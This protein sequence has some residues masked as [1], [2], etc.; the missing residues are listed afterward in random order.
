MGLAVRKARLPQVLRIGA[1]NHDLLPREVCAQHQLVE[2]VD[3]GAAVP[4]RGDRVGEPHRGRVPFRALGLI[5]DVA[6]HRDLE[7]VDPHREPVGTRHGERPFFE[8][9]HAHGLQHRQQLA[10]RGRSPAEVPDQLRRAI[11]AVLGEHQLDRVVLQL[12]DDRDVVDCVTGGDCL[13]VDLWERRRVVLGL[14]LVDRSGLDGAEQSVAPR[15][16][17]LGKQV[18]NARLIAKGHVDVLRTRPLRQPDGEMH[19]RPWRFADPGGVLDAFACEL[20]DQD[21]L[22]LQ[23]DDGGVSVTR[24]VHQTGDEVGELVCAQKQ[25]RPPARAE[26]HD[27]HGHIQQLLRAQREQLRARDRLDDVEQ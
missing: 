14:D 2:A 9:D 24:Q 10:Q 7:L 16:R 5:G 12:F 13:L 4:D 3:L 8:H 15:P 27:A 22:H 19:D 21:V 6:E 23:P 25:Q 20:A 1:Q 26:V 11:P 18:L 17:R